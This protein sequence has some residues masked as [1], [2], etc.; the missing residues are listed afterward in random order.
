MIRLTEPVIVRDILRPPLS[1]VTPSSSAMRSSRSAQ[2]TPLRSAADVE[3]KSNDDRMTVAA[4]A[5]QLGFMAI[6]PPR[7]TKEASRLLRTVTH[8]TMIVSKGISGLLRNDELL[9]VIEHH[10]RVG[11][12][13]TAGGLEINHLLSSSTI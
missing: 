5:I 3:P 9:V 1:A 2:Q 13:Q 8:S 12:G 11:C 7:K 6:P 4:N 10:R